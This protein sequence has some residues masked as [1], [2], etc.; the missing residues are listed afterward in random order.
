MAGTSA[1][2]SESAS[3]WK[4]ICLG[5]WVGCGPREYSSIMKTSNSMHTIMRAAADAAEEMTVAFACLEQAQDG[6]VLKPAAP[7]AV[8]PARRSDRTDSYPSRTLAGPS[9]QANR[10][11]REGADHPERGAR[12][13]RDRP[14]AFPVGLRQNA[15]PAPSRRFIPPNRSPPNASSRA[16]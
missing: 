13:G 11:T 7:S 12:H 15:D 14:Y 9:L 16:F 5:I 4:L 6:P 8:P 2:S 3:T 1:A 10:K